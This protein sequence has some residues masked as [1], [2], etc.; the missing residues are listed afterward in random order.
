MKERKTKREERWTIVQEVKSKKSET[1]KGTLSFNG[2]RTTS[3]HSV[4]M[5]GI[6]LSVGIIIAKLTDGSMLIHVM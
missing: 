2:F 6:H 1:G 4:S 5:R 3:V